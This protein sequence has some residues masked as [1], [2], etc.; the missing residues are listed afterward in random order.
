[1]V[2]LNNITQNSVPAGSGLPDIDYTMCFANFPTI[3]TNIFDLILRPM[4]PPFAM[5]IYNSTST[6]LAITP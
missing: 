5:G 4:M 1:M 3:S 2:T 6:G